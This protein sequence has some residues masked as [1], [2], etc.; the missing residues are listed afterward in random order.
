MYDIRLAPNHPNTNHL[1]SPALGKKYQFL[2]CQTNDWFT[3]L[4]DV[5]IW[6]YT[7]NS[8]ANLNS[9]LK[10][11]WTQ[12]ADNIF[13]SSAWEWTRSCFLFLGKGECHHYDGPDIGIND[14]TK[15]IFLPDLIWWLESQMATSNIKRLIVCKS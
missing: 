7:C 13:Q 3:N 11:S 9:N 1:R 2:S 14:I 4:F 5:F 12:T 8:N 6:F 10:S 15:M